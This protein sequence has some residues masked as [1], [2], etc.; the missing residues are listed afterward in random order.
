M[1][2]LLSLNKIKDIVFTLSIFSFFYWVFIQLYFLNQI[3]LL[4]L[5]NW[6]QSLSD[7]LIA[8]A[9]IIVPLCIFLISLFILTHKKFYPYFKKKSIALIISIPLFFAFFYIELFDKNGTLYLVFNFYFNF[10]VTLLFLFLLYVLIIETFKNNKELKDDKLGFIFKILVCVIPILI[11]WHKLPLIL[12][13]YSFEVMYDWIEYKSYYQNWKYV[14]INDE[15]NIW[16]AIPIDKI[17][18]FVK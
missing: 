3:N 14:L 1:K 7:S 4:S 5:F 6:S 17:D 10:F 8:F 11:F 18:Y 12:N 13:I 16:K 2:E 15:N 9:L